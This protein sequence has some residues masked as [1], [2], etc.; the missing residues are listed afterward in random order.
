ME[1]HR[2]H[3]VIEVAWTN[4][5]GLALICTLAAIHRK[6]NGSRLG[7]ILGMTW[8]D[9]RDRQ[10]SQPP[11]RQFKAVPKDAVLCSMAKQK[12]LRQRIWRNLPSPNW[13][14]NSNDSLPFVVI[15]SCYSFAQGWRTPNKSNKEVS[16][17][18]TGI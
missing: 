10:Q 5:N 11:I 16:M 4:Q 1:V 6:Q 15:T 12:R 14:T 7:L 18:T 2:R 17:P 13:T 8:E 3:E 9:L